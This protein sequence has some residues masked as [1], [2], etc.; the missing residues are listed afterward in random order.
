MYT[1]DSTKCRW[2]LVPTIEVSESICLDVLNPELSLLKLQGF[3]S[4]PSWQGRSKVF[5]FISVEAGIENNDRLPLTREYP[6]STAFT[7][8]VRSL[9]SIQHHWRMVRRL[10]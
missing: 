4:M 6:I 8:T 2:L 7:A 3:A 10:W 5:A 1:A 9:A